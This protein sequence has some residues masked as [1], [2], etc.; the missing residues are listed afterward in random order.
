[1]RQ[2][3]TTTKRPE[4]LPPTETALKHHTFRTEVQVHQWRT[5]SLPAV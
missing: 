5:S 1:M 3:V 4:M 2:V